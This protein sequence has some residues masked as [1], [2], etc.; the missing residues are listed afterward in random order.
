MKGGQ[1]AIFGPSSQYHSCLNAS[2]SYGDYIRSRKSTIYVFPRCPWSGAYAW[3]LVHSVKGWEL[4]FPVELMAQTN[5]VWQNQAW[6]TTCQVLH[7]DVISRQMKHALLNELTPIVFFKNEG[8]VCKK[9]S[10]NFFFPIVI[11]FL[12]ILTRIICLNT[13]CICLQSYLRYI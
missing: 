11:K 13:A 10:V 4:F 8:I 6:G 3:R 2:R 9:Q 1:A 12:K 5:L 7:S